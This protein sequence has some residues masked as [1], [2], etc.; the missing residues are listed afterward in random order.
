MKRGNVTSSFFRL[1]S[2][3]HQRCTAVFLR[4]VPGSPAACL[5]LAL[6]FFFL[7]LL[8]P[9]P[10]LSPPPLAPTPKGCIAR[11]LRPITWPGRSLDKAA[12][13]KS[14]HPDARCLVY[15]HRARNTRGNE[16]VIG[17]DWLAPLRLRPGIGHPAR[18]A[19]HR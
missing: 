6:F 4:S 12:D 15:G 19:S 17:K 7:L 3:L 5:V 1:A 11:I 18:A 8:L 14:V 13:H 2:T 10:L 16:Q 9:P